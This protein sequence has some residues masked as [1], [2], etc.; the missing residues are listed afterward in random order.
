MSRPPVSPT[1]ARE[2]ALAPAEILSRLRSRFGQ[3][4]TA[5]GEHAGQV[6]AVVP[7]EDNLAVLDFLR[8]DPTIELDMLVDVTVV[9][10]LFLELEQ[11]PERFA[12][13]YELRSIRHGHRF[14]LKAPVPEDDPRIASVCEL[15]KSA[16]W[17]E[18]E[19]HDMFGVEFEG[20]PDLRRLLM[21]ADFSGFPL[22]KDFPLRGQGERDGFP[23]VRRHALDEEDES[24]EGR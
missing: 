7:R 14:R 5:S 16:L 22:R 10:H 23:K 2:T 9:D 4:V 21:P 17:G 8:T 6:F 20:N 11:V 24:D 1:A 12:V 19:A 3:T 15:W 18:R 13:V